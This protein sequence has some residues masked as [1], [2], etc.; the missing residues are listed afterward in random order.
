MS[1]FGWDIPHLIR[2]YLILL[3][4]ASRKMYV[5]SKIKLDDKE[6]SLFF[7]ARKKWKRWILIP[8]IYAHIVAMFFR[9][10]REWRFKHLDGKVRDILEKLNLQTRVIRYYFTLI[11]LIIISLRKIVRKR[12]GDMPR[13][14]VTK[15]LIPA[16]ET[17]NNSRRGRKYVYFKFQ[18]FRAYSL[19][20]TSPPSP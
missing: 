14:N 13:W 20:F 18:V 3:S 19:F 4:I 11:R 9:V 6:N 2:L 1:G 15:R 7:R 16:F 5:F 10:T 17:E 8:W 12:R